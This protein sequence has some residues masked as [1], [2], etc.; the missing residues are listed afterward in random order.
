MIDRLKTGDKMRWLLPWAKDRLLGRVRRIAPGKHL[1]VAICDHFEPL[2]GGAAH[3]RGEKRVARFRRA[4]PEIARAFRDD[5]GLNP[6]HTFFYPGEQYAH[7]LVEPLAE[8]CEMGFGEVEVHLHHD[9]DSRA[10]LKRA[11]E[12]SLD[13]LDGHGLVSRV[14]GQRKW[15]FI[16]GNWAL[17]NGR[18]DGRWCG[19]DDELDL[20]WELGCYADFTFPSAPDVCQPPHANRIFYPAGDTS[21]RRSYDK[22]DEAYAGKG[23][24]D[25]V[26]LI[27][28][29]LA[30]SRRETR[31]APRIEASALTAK[32]PA[33]RARLRTWIDCHVHVRGRPEWVFIKLHTHGAPERE[34]EALL[35]A[36]QRSFHEELGALR[37]EGRCIHYVTAREMFNI[38]AAA[39]MGR[40]GWPGAYRDYI[41]PPPPR[42][43]HRSWRESN[44]ARSTKNARGGHAP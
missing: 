39:M 32:D 13:D 29:P 24:R 37:D 44:V 3:A 35:G 9:G 19:V 21:H 8:L 42:A 40:S 6:R 4:Y 22:I 14:D 36:P 15:A 25:R 34:A 12:T 17:A 18:P 38:A 26:L 11:L 1:I 7:T 30:L 16:H 10:S 28:G 43:S 41:V 31:L 2:H 5:D 23:M 27:T 33:S 20:L